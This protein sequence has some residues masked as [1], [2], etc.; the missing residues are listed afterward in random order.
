MAP[1]L[2]G[3]ILLVGLRTLPF[4]AVIE[5]EPVTD[6]DWRRVAALNNGEWCDAVCHARGVRGRWSNAAWVQPRRGPPFYPNLVTLAPEP[7]AEQLAA[8]AGLKEALPHGFAVK[9]SFANLDLARLGFRPLFEAEWICLAAGRA[10]RGGSR[11]QRV[12]GD[13]ALAEWEAAWAAS[14]SPAATRVFLPPLLADD[15]IAFFATRSAGEIVAGCAA[16]RSAEAVGFSNFFARRDQE[17]HRRAAVA[18][19]AEFA[20]DK[21]V[22]GYESDAALCESLRLGFTAVGPLRIWFWESG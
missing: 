7:A 5:R 22:V 11:W 4:F 19:V 15:R 9:D 16:N 6:S 21:A 18:A 1:H 12:D 14:G 20:G 2:A 13:A 8:I 3:F 17:D 10:R